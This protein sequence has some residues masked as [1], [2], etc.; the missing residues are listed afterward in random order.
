VVGLLGRQGMRKNHRQ[1]AFGAS[2]LADRG[3]GHVRVLGVRHGA[4]LS[5]AA[6]VE[7]STVLREA[8]DVELLCRIFCRTLA[9][10]AAVRGPHERDAPKADI[11][12]RVR[13]VR[14]A[15]TDIQPYSI[16]SSAR[17]IRSSGTVMPRAFAVLRLMMSS[18]F[19]ACWT[20]KSAGFSPF[21][22]LPV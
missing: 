18:T 8:R 2:P 15:P 13:N 9:D 14:F 10:C 19:V 21:R 1:P 3:F 20:G 5:N 17:P 12:R 11:D 22:I 16:T 6:P 7:W 4:S